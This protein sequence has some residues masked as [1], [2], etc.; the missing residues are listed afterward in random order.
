MKYGI[1]LLIGVLTLA[2]C[3]KEEIPLFTMEYIVSVPF[4]P[5]T[6]TT[7]T[8]RIKQRNISSQYDKLLLENNIK[9]E[10][11]KTV[12][13]RSAVI[14]PAG[15]SVDY[16]V[17]RKIDISIFENADPD[18]LLVIAE[19]YPPLN[20]RRNELPMLPGLPNLKSYL[21]QD[22]F[23]LDVGYIL[24]RPISQRLD[25]FVRLELEVIGQ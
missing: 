24:R 7:I 9:P 1:C 22:Y 16:S 20:E 2:S 3:T 17:L 15:Q 5:S 10:D 14:Y 19:E 18:D 21:E 25:N 12:R 6:N 8:Y 11:V 13:V 23:G 4:E